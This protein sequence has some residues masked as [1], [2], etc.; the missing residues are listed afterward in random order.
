MTHILFITYQCQHD[1]NNYLAI[2]IHLIQSI[3]INYKAMNTAIE[4]Y[5]TKYLVFKLLD[6][7]NMMKKKKKLTNYRLI[8]KYQLLL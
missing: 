3:M 1:V 6:T 8:I 5:Y 4:V 7:N 2:S